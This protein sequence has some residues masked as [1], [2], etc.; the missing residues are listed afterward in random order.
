MWYSNNRIFFSTTEV[1]HISS[2]WYSIAY[3]LFKLYFQLPKYK[4]KN[5]ESY[6]IMHWKNLI[7]ISVSS[8]FSIRSISVISSSFV[9]RIIIGSFVWGTL[10]S[11][12]ELVKPKW[13]FLFI[14]L[15]LDRPRSAWS[16]STPFCALESFI[17][18]KS[19]GFLEIVQIFCTSIRFLINILSRSVYTLRYWW[20]ISPWLR[21]YIISL[22]IIVTRI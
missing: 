8:S 22:V 18:Y 9:G 21:I 16:T 4:R 10:C 6:W 19:G 11:G 7:L 12:Q 3:K 14:P 13:I 17:R 20:I 15:E 1:S 5:R 2:L